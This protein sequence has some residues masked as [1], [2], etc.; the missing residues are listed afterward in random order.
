MGDEIVKC[1]RCGDKIQSYSPMRKWCVE[2]RHAISL[3]Q[4]KARKTAK[5][6]T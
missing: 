4:A 1:Q 2:C 5:K 3:E 6:K